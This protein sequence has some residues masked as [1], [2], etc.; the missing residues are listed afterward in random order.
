M[1][2]C[3]VGVTACTLMHPHAHLF[4]D[5]LEEAL[6]ALP[7]LL[8]IVS[9]EPVGRVQPAGERRAGSGMSSSDMC[10]MTNASPLERLQQSL[11]SCAASCATCQ[12]QALEGRT[13]CMALQT[14]D[15]VKIR[16][17]MQVD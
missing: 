17:A 2:P 12:A 8:V 7:I 3:H 16:P 11:C 15:A 4:L 5:I 6:R 10:E 1:V 14:L 13:V 9:I